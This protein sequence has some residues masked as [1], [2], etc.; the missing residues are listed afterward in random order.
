MSSISD[1]WPKRRGFRV[2][3]RFNSGWVPS[4]AEDFLVMLKR[5]ANLLFALFL[6][7]CPLYLHLVNVVEHIF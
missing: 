7:A 1:W 3:L 2:C 4:S 5:Y 6:G